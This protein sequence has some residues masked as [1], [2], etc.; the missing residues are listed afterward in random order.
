MTLTTPT[1][2]PNH[3]EPSGATA[4]PGD[5]AAL[6]AG[7]T[8]EEK[9][10][11]CSGATMWHTKAVARLGIEP[12]M[13]SDGPH[14]LRAQEVTEDHTPGIADAHPATCF[15]TAAALGSSWDPRLL[16]AVGRAI[17]AEARALGVHVVLGPGVNIK[18]SPLCGRNFEYLSEDPALTGL[19]ATAFVDG[20]QSQGVGTSLKHFAANNQETDR[21]RVDA[22]VDERTLREVYL[23]G[24]ERPITQA[25]PWTVMCAYN[26]VNGVHASQHPWLL[27][28]VLREDW[29][30]EGAVMSDWGAVVDR[31][32][33]LAAGLDLEM[34]S[35]R[36]V[37]DAQIVDAV[38]SGRL[39]ESVLDRTVARLLRLVATA[40]ASATDEAPDDADALDLDA[41]HALAREVAAQCAVLLKNDG[42]LLPLDPAGTARIAVIGEFARTPRYQG[43]GSSQV[44]ATRVEDALTAMREVAGDRV[45]FAPGFT[46]DADADP[47][48]PQ[49]VQLRAE[50][51]AAAAAADVVVAFLGL[52]RSAESEGFDRTH[53]R[54]PQAQLDLLADVAAV[55][56]QV[57]VV[58]ANGA[59]VDVASWQGQARA[60]LEGWL[61]GQAGGG[62]VADLLFG[63]AN[64][65]GRLAESIPLS[66]ADVPA[67]LN[68]PGE[69]GAVRYGEGLFVGYRGLDA[70]QRDVAYPFGHGLSYTSFAW[71]DLAVDV[72][73]G[74]DLGAQAA[75]RLDG[76]P[77]VT[78][79]LTV[80]NTGTRAGSDVVQVYVGDPAAS[81]TRP[82]REL[83]AFAKV[84][85]AP[86][87]S[88]RVELSLTARD[89]A[90][91][92]P[93]VRRWVVEPGA[94]DIAVGASSRDLRLSAT[95]DVD[96][97]ALV[98]PLDEESTIDE[99]V[100]HP[101][102]G[103]IVA[104]LL[105]A[106][107]PF[108]DPEIRM[109]LG[110]MPMVRLLD[111]PGAP[112]TRE[113]F[114]ALRARVNA[115]A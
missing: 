8:L 23:S 3:D 34:P 29:G 59:V 13:L 71:S 4:A 51:V 62:A 101:V 9:A 53:L 72:V 18:R 103:P 1:A 24:F 54:L 40:T 65:S 10:S 64:P 107:G 82:V 61:L 77:V 50:A 98:L 2:S 12:I 79:G 110:S 84:A 80:T 31:V 46:L 32:A 66:L 56:P 5:V 15:P 111:W 115:E 14:G 94:F 6:I 100:A 88:R 47:S 38:R 22:Q 113:E 90:F 41:H 60:V 44:N 105:P 39:E 26:R 55:N 74:A 81:V 93:A 67:S 97:P 37:T 73:A 76:A 27:T 96:A 91:W 102:A 78:L 49:A 69:F 11:L 19:L 52:P 112:V 48:T 99:W 92:H 17:G 42:D 58:L 25:R 108:A 28:R 35:S 68:F 63:A 7:M 36:G 104:P 70:Q 106:E 43:A 95:V 83:K 16:H 21:M 85:L 87:E 57:V 30:F 86:G 89:L 33:A 109:M 114:E 20:V 75:A 45:A